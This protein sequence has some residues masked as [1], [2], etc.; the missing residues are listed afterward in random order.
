MKAPDSSSQEVPV[1]NC[2]NCGVPLDL[3]EVAPLTVVECPGCGQSMAVLRR[4]GPFELE[5]LLGQGGTGAVYRAVDTLLQRPIALKVL[6]PVWSSHAGVVAQFKQEAVMAALINHPGV[7][8]VYSTGVAFGMFYIALELADLGGLDVR[9]ETLGRLP[10][11][12]VLEIFGQAAEA[13]AAAHGAG[14]IHRD[15]KPGNILFAGN[16]RVKIVDF[17]LALR[18]EQSS[19]SR[20]LE[21]LWGTPYYIAPEM[22]S[23]Q[24]V[25][26]RADLY[27]LGASMWHA[28]VGEPPYPAQTTSIEELLELKRH[29]VDVRRVLPGV[30]P[31]IAALLNR[32][33]AFDARQRFD[34]YESLLEEIRAVREGSMR[35]RRGA[36]TGMGILGAAALFAAC[37]G[38]VRWMSRAPSSGA[39]ASAE[40]DIP[41]SGGGVALPEDRERLRIAFAAFG[42]GEF[43]HGLK[44]LHLVTQTPVAYAP[45]KAWAWIGLAAMQALQ[46]REEEGLQVLGNFEKWASAEEPSFVPLAKTVRAAASGESLGEPHSNPDV[47]MASQI[48]RAVYARSRGNAVDVQIALERAIA[49]GEQARS[50]EAADF[51][52]M[53]QEAL[54][55]SP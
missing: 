50:P 46:Q 25:D 32:C 45:V 48:F 26:F 54:R 2:Q 30:N 5:G 38:A 44:I 43:A 19:D 20:V 7:V 49:A 28:L 17:G 52:R 6:Q 24:V 14:L 41:S 36:R 33:V 11:G 29:R 9:M 23:G 40:G 13:L 39:L 12:E 51:L 37:F 4:F 10:E 47:E 3:R 27:A 55:K 16:G 53:A 35:Q 42:E 34:S 22:L 1:E 15:I 21:E 8:R 31:R 18:R